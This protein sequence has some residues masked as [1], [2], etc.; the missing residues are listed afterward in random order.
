MAL[1]SIKSPAM[2]GLRKRKLPGRISPDFPRTKKRQITLMAK[3]PAIFF[4][5]IKYHAGIGILHGRTEQEKR[6]I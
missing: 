3:L 6:A 2:S 4:K 1:C 5:M